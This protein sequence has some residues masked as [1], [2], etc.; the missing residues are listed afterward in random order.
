MIYLGVEYGTKL[1]L[2][3]PESYNGET[4]TNL[5]P[6]ASFES[7]AITG[8]VSGSDAGLTVGGPIISTEW[9]ADDAFSL[10]FSASNFE[11]STKSGRVQTPNGT[12]GI[13]VTAGKTYALK[14]WTNFKILTTSGEVALFIRW[15]NS[16]GSLVSIS[17][18]PF[19]AVIGAQSTQL[20]AVAPAGAAFAAVGVF[21][22]VL[23]T[24]GFE[25][26]IDSV[27]FEQ[28][29]APN[30]QFAPTHAQSERGDLIWSGTAWL[31][32]VAAKVRTRTI[33]TFN[34]PTDPDFVGIL[35]PESS[36]LDAP[37]IREDSNDRV[38]SDGA[39]FGDF[40][41]G[42]R[43]VVLQ[44][45]I[46]AST[47]TQRNERVG[48]LRAAS[49]AKTADATLWW[50]DDA[51][52]K[53]FVNLR[54][55]QPLRITKGWLKEFQLAM[56]AADSRILSYAVKTAFDEGITSGS[57]EKFPTVTGQSWSWFAASSQAAWTSTANIVS[58]NNVYAT[59][60]E[61]SQFT[62]NM[63]YGKAYGFSIPSTALVTGV[64]VKPEHKASTNNSKSINS[65][66]INIDIA[67]D[68]KIKE[69]LNGV[70]PNTQQYSGY[71]VQGI[72]FPIVELTTTD[73]TY[74]IG[75]SADL[76]K[77]QTYLTP[78]N[79]NAANFG[80]GVLYRSIALKSIVSVDALP[81][82]VTYAEPMLVTATNEGDAPAPAVIKIKGPL[83]N[84]YVLNQTTG[85]ILTYT[86]KVEAG[87]EIWFDT[88]NVTVTE[89]GAGI[90][91]PINRFGN[92]GLPNDWIRI[93][94]GANTIAVAGAS[95]SGATKVTVEYRDAWE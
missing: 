14:L 78:T 62:S 51:A 91:E 1:T 43:P 70:A 25:V 87:K 89:H 47:L 22:E 2:E 37:E 55:Q 57:Q 28:A 24:K 94:P 66:V 30:P 40:F 13:P 45:R 3:S 32:S 59:S 77:Y 39:I 83:E 48:K 80:A 16:S 67:N 61:F 21:V 11:V 65:A 93:F 75:G 88:E 84:F 74:V 90:V 12:S 81:I 23:P 26:F 7:G 15:Y 92:V 42:K 82:K 56:V 41:S 58:S 60:A 50:E 8:W 76:W 44:G 49:L 5:I 95:G 19:S 64:E 31:S 4:T 36:G 68:A 34:D 73:S 35:D 46:I 10:K 20:S 18:L 17:S 29:V 69:D 85:E 52:G 86:G 79:I 71:H 33:A 53:V 27:Q 72:D 38:E 9:S 6:N 63:I 54:R